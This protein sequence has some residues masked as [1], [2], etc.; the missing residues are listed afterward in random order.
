MLTVEERK[1]RNR[2]LET[3]AKR[4][5]ESRGAPFFGVAER[6]VLQMRVQISQLTQAN[7]Q[8]VDNLNLFG[9]EK[10]ELKA[11]VKELHYMVRSLADVLANKGVLTDKEFNERIKKRQL[12][13]LALTEVDRRIEA[14]DLITIKFKFLDGEKVVDDRTQQPM[15]YEMGTLG[16]PCE[17]KFIGMRKGEKAIIHNIVFG[18]SFRIKEY[19]NKPMTM[20]VLICGVHTRAKP[21]PI[22]EISAE[23]E[24]LEVE[25]E[26]T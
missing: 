7:K 26:P 15:L 6:D 1:A 21:E 14:K 5:L 8:M 25:A 20:D 18:D 12:N 23:V 2:D 11:K 13:D 10:E 22:E 19:A 17:E 4:R 9:K 24:Q 3:K 16:L